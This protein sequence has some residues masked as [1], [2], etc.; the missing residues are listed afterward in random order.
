MR[1]AHTVEQ[2]RAAEHALMATVPDG[3]LMQ[4]AAY[5]L[6]TAC[7]DYL[8]YSYGA[9]IVVLAGSGDNGGDALYAGAI[10]ARRGARVDAVVL[11][12]AK[13]HA[14]GLAALRRAGGL[15]YDADTAPAR[16]FEDARLGLDGIVGI[17][18][19]PGLRANAAAVL[20]RVEAAGVPIVAVDLPSGIDVDTGE[21]PDRHVRA[22][23]TVTFGTHK[24]GLLTDPGATAAG[25]V[26]LVDIGLG[27]YLPDPALEALTDADVAERLPEPARESHKYTR[28]VLGVVAGSP[29]YAGAATLLVGGALGMPLGMVRYAG[30][31]AVA[32]LVRQ[33][34]PE[35]VAGEGRVQAWAV[36]S[37]LGE[38]PA[39][40]DDVGRVLESGVPV[41]VDADGLRQLPARCDGPVLLTPHAGEL[42]RLL[43]VD[44]GSVEA[45][46]LHWAREVATRRNATVLLKG[47]ST[48]VVAPDGRARVNPVASP[49]AATAGSGD[50]LTGICGAL[51][52]AGLDPFDAGSVGAYVHGAASVLASGGGPTTA[53]AIAAAVTP[54]VRPLLATA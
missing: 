46:R 49:W 31:G 54:A 26:E 53:G 25:S 34:Y 27:P 41:V 35:V 51:L 30:S 14:G 7:V 48:L 38:D 2:V 33:R 29:E 8:G 32:D 12:A 9:P 44:R 19:K 22:E 42:A 24:I 39:R 28:G 16:L 13:A 17:G 3:T 10:L 5:G 52:A 18:G 20:D 15:V 37:G 43:D 36:G 11:D 21:T 1:R 45:R 47:A 50:V 40:A 23:L 6:A 4:R